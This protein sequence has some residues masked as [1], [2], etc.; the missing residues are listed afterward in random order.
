MSVEP[1]EIHLVT[2]L[3][4]RSLSYPGVDNVRCPTH[5]W[6]EVITTCGVLRPIIMENL[7]GENF[8]TWVVYYAS[9]HDA[10]VVRQDGEMVEIPKNWLVL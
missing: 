6:S 9:S 1:Q 8:W 4:E 2:G 7:D 5:V 10:W 3:V